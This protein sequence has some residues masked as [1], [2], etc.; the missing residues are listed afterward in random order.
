MRKIFFTLTIILLCSKTFS[1][2][3]LGTGLEIAVS[4]DMLYEQGLNS[5]SQANELLTMRGAEIVFFSPV[6]HQFNGVLSAAAHYEDG[7][8]VFELHELYLSSSKIIPRSNF[9]VGQFF[10]G[11]GRLNRFHQ[12]DWP[13]TRAPKIH[14]SFF[15]DEGVYDSGLEYNYLL[16]TTHSLNLTV[17]LTSGHSYGHSHTSGS[18][19]KVPTHYFRLSSFSPFSSTSGLDLGLNYLGRTDA[20]KNDMKLIGFDFTGKS[21][22]GRIVDY[23]FLSEI[24]YKS[25]ENANKEVSEQVGTYIFNDFSTGQFTNIGFRLDAFKD[26]SKTNSI[27]NK[28]INNISYGALTQLTYTSSEFAKIRF[29]LAHEFDREEGHTIAKDTRAQ[30][31]L[32][33]IIGS[34]PAHD[35]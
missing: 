10:L 6:D 32:I 17:G 12:H 3:L 16:P 2:G 22:H 18:K 26:L 15:D 29:T 4:G 33:L 20:Q 34:H 8:T 31:Q 19:P 7:Q 14:R 1:Q 27:T 11:I 30:L 28:K 23:L 13:F 35:F 24:W 21:K 9:K 25:V 5:D